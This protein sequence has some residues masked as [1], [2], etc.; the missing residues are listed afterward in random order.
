ME[1]TCSNSEVDP[2][3]L[4]GET[5]KISISLLSEMKVIK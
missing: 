4:V 5:M 2:L 1:F 3:M